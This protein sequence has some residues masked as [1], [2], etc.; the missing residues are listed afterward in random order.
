MPE[1]LVLSGKGG[2]GK[3]TL[4]ASLAHLSGSGGQAPVI[5]DLDVDAPDL[6]LLLKPKTYAT[7]EFHSGNEAIIKPEECTG[8]GDCVEACRF[9]A[10]ELIDGKA[11]V[12]PFRCEGCKVC[13][14]LCPAQAVDFPVRYCGNWYQSTCR[15]GS[16][17]HA[18]LFPG[19][20]NSGRLVALLRQEARKIAE[21]QNSQIIISDGPPGIGCPVISSLSGT[22]L[23][24][25]ITEPTQSGLHDLERVVEL[26]SHFRVPAA[27]VIN[28]HDLNPAMSQE[29]E[30]YCSKESLPLV[31][32]LP[33][34]SKV[35][36][37][38]LAGLSISEFDPQGLGSELRLIWSKVDQLTRQDRAA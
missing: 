22:D 17:V 38:M 7:H 36:E 16:M 1:I 11:V 34:S 2:T 37:A 24:L 9:D 27:V 10:L 13:V 21:E 4:T 6:H 32:R 12:N 29:V 33:H 26:S 30:A 19:Q 35:V 14:T 8:C 25:I 18:Q 20:E 23:A 28:K 5:C 3:T 31:G 15:L